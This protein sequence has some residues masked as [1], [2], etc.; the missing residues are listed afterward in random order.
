MKKHEWE[1][2]RAIV[3]HSREE[4]VCA[5]CLEKEFQAPQMTHCGHVFCWH[6]IYMHHYKCTPPTTQLSRPTIAP[7]AISSTPSTH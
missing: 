6:C 7:S 1:R 4:L 5:I 2:V 3:Y